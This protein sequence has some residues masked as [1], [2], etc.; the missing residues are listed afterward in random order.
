MFCISWQITTRPH[1]FLAHGTISGRSLSRLADVFRKPSSTW[2]TARGF[3]A[4]GLRLTSLG[5]KVGPEAPGTAESQ[6]W[7]AVQLR[8][9]NGWYERAKHCIAKPSWSGGS[10]KN[11]TEPRKECRTTCDCSTAGMR[12]PRM[13][14]DSVQVRLQEEQQAEQPIEKLIEQ[15]RSEHQSIGLGLS[16]T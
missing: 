5:S 12:E 14:K 10:L 4:I 3:G 16:S 2:T 6:E 1:N 7:N 9:F 11:T 15:R 13:A 8:P